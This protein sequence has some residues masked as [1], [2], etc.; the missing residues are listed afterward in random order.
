MRQNGAVTNE[1]DRPEPTPDEGDTAPLWER[2]EAHA[3]PPPEPEDATEPQHAAEPEP[4][5]RAVQ[6]AQPFGSRLRAAARLAGLRPPYQPSTQQPPLRQQ[7]APSTSPPTSRRPTRYAAAPLGPAGPTRPRR[8]SGARAGCG[9]WSPPPRWSWAPSA[10]PSAARSWPTRASGDGGFFDTR[11]PVRRLATSATSTAAAAGRQQQ[12]RRRRG[13]G[14]AQHRPG[15]ARRRR[16]HAARARPAPASWSTARATSS[17]TTTSSRAPPATASRGRRPRRQVHGAEI[18]GRS[19]VYDIA[20]L[21]VERRRGAAAG[22]ARLVAR[23]A[24]RRDRRRDR[25]AARA[26][27]HRHLGHRQRAGPAGHHRRR[28]ATTRRTS[29]PCRPTPRS[30]PATP[31]ARW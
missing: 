25:L 13:R 3:Y 21:E 5:A 6:P 17:P 19:P 14:A 10:A 2:P 16:R 15:H 31:A 18:V 20:V 26:L 27:Q 22:R 30:T 28:A 9:R 12:R 4:R 29:T 23:D 11:R 24:R 7:P 1:Q 8:G